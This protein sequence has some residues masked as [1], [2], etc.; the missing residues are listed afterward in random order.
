MNILDAE[1]RG[2][3]VLLG[4]AVVGDAIGAD[5][6]VKLGARPEH[7]VLD[8]NG[9]LVV[10]VKM[11]EPLG[12][13]TLLHGQI[14]GVPQTFTASLQGVHLMKEKNTEMR[15][16]VQPDKVHL[17]DTQTGLRRVASPR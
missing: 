2:G 3:K 1:V 16:S 13:N 17:F 7:L 5:G 12:A 10:A 8:P 9:P 14:A 4:D 15:F 6:P 11:T